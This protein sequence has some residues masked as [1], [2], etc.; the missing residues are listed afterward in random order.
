MDNLKTTLSKHYNIRNAQLTE[1][2]P[3][4]SALAYCVEASDRRFF[5]KVYGK[6]RYTVQFWIEGIDRYIPALIWLGEHTALRGR[7]PSI[8][9]TTDGSYKYENEEQLYILFDWID[10]TTPRDKPLTPLQMSE[11]SLLIAKLHGFDEGIPAFSNVLRES[12]DIHF[13]ESLLSRAQSRDENIPREYISLI[14]EKLLQL[15]ETSNMLTAL[16]LPFVLCHNDIHGWNVITQG[17]NLFLLD[18]E[19][20]KLAPAEADLFMFKYERYWGQRW[21]EFYDVYRK[22]HPNLEINETLMRFFQLRRR[23]WDIDEFVS[24]ITL[25]NES[26]EVQEEAKQALIRECALL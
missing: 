10:G 9:K 21:D 6:M 12:Y 17:N 14:I 13:Y 25:D 26:V 24:N 2:I 8:V 4:W 1:M 11:L 23:L 16:N 22:T 7:I 5:L 18:W 15:K 19:G 20:L 3:G